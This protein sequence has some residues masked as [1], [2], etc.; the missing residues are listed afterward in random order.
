MLGL[1]EWKRRCLDGRSD[2]VCGRRHADKQEANVEIVGSSDTGSTSRVWKWDN[3][4]KKYKRGNT[5]KLLNSGKLK[6]VKTTEDIL[7]SKAGTNEGRV[8][9]NV[10]YVE[11]HKA[12]S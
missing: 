8:M 4:R 12:W 5:T 10:E 2:D 9:R 6:K 11:G 7:V 3:M 1:R